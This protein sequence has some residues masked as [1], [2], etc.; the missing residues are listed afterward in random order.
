MLFWW[1]CP[2]FHFL[3]YNINS[4]SSPTLTYS[5]LLIFTNASFH[6]LIYNINVVFSP[7]LT[8]LNLFLLTIVSFH[9]L[10]YNL[11]IIFSPTL[12]HSNIF[13]F[14]TNLLT[15]LWCVRIKKFI[16]CVTCWLTCLGCLIQK[17]RIFL[18][19]LDVPSFLSFLEFF[20]L[21]SSSISAALCLL[22]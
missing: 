8:Y 6:L 21:F 9:F 13:L 11:N 15:L 1:G 10:I 18:E 14:T 16:G 3:I 12:T 5:N 2:S 19:G 22:D 17:N 20:P 4:T 7:T